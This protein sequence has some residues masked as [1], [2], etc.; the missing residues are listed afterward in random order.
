MRDKLELLG[1][2]GI[3]EINFSHAIRVIRV[4]SIIRL[5]ELL[6]LFGY[7]S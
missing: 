3:L 7:K 6:G 2:F 5:F 4:N 1:L